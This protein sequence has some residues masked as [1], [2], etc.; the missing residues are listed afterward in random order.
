MVDC[1]HKAKRKKMPRVAFPAFCHSSPIPLSSQMPYSN[2]FSNSYVIFLISKSVFHSVSPFFVS[3]HG[4]NSVSA[5]SEGEAAHLQSQSEAV[6]GA[7]RREGGT[8]LP[9]PVT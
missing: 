7:H 8:Y 5:W 4:Q 1:F 2:R 9:Q 6:N 3:C